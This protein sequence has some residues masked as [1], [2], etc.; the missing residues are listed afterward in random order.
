MQSSSQITSN[1]TSP[2][3]YRPDVLSC[4]PTNSVTA[5]WILLINFYRPNALPGTLQ[6][7]LRISVV[8]FTQQGPHMLEVP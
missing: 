4:R 3:I 2:N 1:K 6:H 8:C 7:W 5:Q